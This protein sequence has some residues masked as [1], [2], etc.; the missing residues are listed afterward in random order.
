M[1]L[2]QYLCLSLQENLLFAMT[3][4]REFAATIRVHESRYTRAT[5]AVVDREAAGLPQRL[6]GGRPP[7]V[8]D[9]EWRAALT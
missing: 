8:H 5:W 3:I 7:S 6:D 4:C 9:A 1:V 2:G